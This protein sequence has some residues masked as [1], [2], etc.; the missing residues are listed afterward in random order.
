MVISQY[1]NIF[2]VSGLDVKSR[3]YMLQY[4]QPFQS[5]RNI[6]YSWI[7]S[8]VFLLSENGHIWHENYV[9]QMTSTSG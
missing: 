2:N 3:F 8:D 7:V 9:R 5:R 1:Y 6:S 4:M